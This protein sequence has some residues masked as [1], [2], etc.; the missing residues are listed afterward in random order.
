MHSIDY[1]LA[2][3]LQERRLDE[4][5]RVYGE[6]H[7]G[8]QPDPRRQSWPARK[9]QPWLYELG[10]YMVELGHRLEGAHQP[11]VSQAGQEQRR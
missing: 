11:L 2:N 1:R 3:A 5:R 9:L 10:G 8:Q 4:V 7:E 6:S